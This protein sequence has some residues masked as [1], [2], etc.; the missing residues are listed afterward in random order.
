MAPV[1]QNGSL[2]ELSSAGKES[3]TY[4]VRRGTDKE[5]FLLASHENNMDV[6]SSVYYH[7]AKSDIVTL[8][9]VHVVRVQDNRSVEICATSS[10]STCRS[11][12][13]AAG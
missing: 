6:Y 13:P 7:H 2:K 11:A 12:G 5:T 3:A 9:Y 10:R 4:V 8:V 1:S